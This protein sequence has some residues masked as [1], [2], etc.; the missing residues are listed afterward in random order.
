MCFSM[1]S[2][3][4]KQQQEEIFSTINTKTQWVN[5]KRHD[6]CQWQIQSIT[7]KL[8]SI[9]KFFQTFCKS[10][11]APCC[12]Q[13]RWNDF[14]AFSSSQYQ[15]LMK[16]HST[17][18]KPALQ[19]PTIYGYLIIT[20]SLLCPWWSKES[21]YISTC[22]SQTPCYTDIFYGPLRVFANRVWLHNDHLGT[23]WEGRGG[24][25]VW[26]PLFW[27]DINRSVAI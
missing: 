21:P 1:S 24:G 12:S 3:S 10:S 13:F 20:D 8:Q 19:T 23:G 11:I 22:L 2:M 14:L 18:V 6:L 27:S 4:K 7:K 9:C 16:H 25:L 26:K 17:T 15:C 5:T